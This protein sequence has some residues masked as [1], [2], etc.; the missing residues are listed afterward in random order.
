M[1]QSG[2]GRAI[3]ASG[4]ER[5]KSQAAVVVEADLAGHAEG[6]LVG[7]RELRLDRRRL[8]DAGECGLEDTGRDRGESP[9]EP[10]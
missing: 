10:L 3:E 2:V 9:S 8:G 4:C 6:V 1:T 7:E 5:A